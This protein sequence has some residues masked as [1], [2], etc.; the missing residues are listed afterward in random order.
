MIKA[1]KE[2]DETGLSDRLRK[3]WLRALAAVETGEQRYAL[4]LCHA[5]L[6]SESGFLRGRILARRCAIRA[7]DSS[8]EKSEFFKQSGNF[9]RQRP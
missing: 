3:L 1:V 2:I 4:S 8:V 5:V 6:K 7:H 9:F